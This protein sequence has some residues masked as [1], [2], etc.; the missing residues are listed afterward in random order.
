MPAGGSA[1]SSSYQGERLET[2]LAFAP[3]TRERRRRVSSDRR[4]LAGR[5]RLPRG[6][7]SLLPFSSYGPVA[8]SE[9]AGSDQEQRD[10]TARSPNGPEDTVATHDERRRFLV[11]ATATV[12][13]VGATVAAWPFVASWLPSAKARALGAPVPVETDGIEPGQQL[14]VA[15]RGRPVWVLHRTPE[16]LERLRHAHWRNGL[17]DP[18]SKVESQQPPYAQNATRSIRPEYLVAVGICTHLGCVPTFRPE[19][20]SKDLG[21]DWMGGYYCPCHG[22]RFDLAG[23][24]VKYVPAPTNLVIPPHRYIGPQT[25]EIG[26]DQV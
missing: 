3:S 2:T 4:Q 19:V 20:P 7:I 14:T 15:W 5:G 8:M 21:A 25:I 22:S 6:P 18:D 23:R 17:S 12:G 9:I 16:M 10:L 11:S 24:V 1:S 26:I 13:V